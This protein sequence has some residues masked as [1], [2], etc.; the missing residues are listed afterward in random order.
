[1]T[2]KIIIVLILVLILLPTRGVLA[3]SGKNILFT[4][5]PNTPGALE[6]VTV[7]IRSFVI[8]LTAS[9]VTWYLDGEEYTKG[10]NLTK[11]D[12]ITEDWGNPTEVKA[13]A[14]LISGKTLTEAITIYPTRVDLLW[15]ANSYTPAFYKGKKL[16]TSGTKII[17]TAEPTLVSEKGL[18][19]PKSL[20]YT[21]QKNNETLSAASG[22]GKKILS[23]TAGSTDDNIKLKVSTQDNRLLAEKQ[24]VINKTKP[25]IDF[26]EVEPLSGINWLK[27]I[28][29]NDQLTGEDITIKAEPYFFAT[30]LTSDNLS[31]SWKV[32]DKVVASREDNPKLI[33]LINSS[34]TGEQ[35]I[36]LAL[37]IKN[38]YQ[39]LQTAQKSLQLKS[40]YYDLGF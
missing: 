11:I 29:N 20:L 14:K 37:N 21:W 7:S 2:R 13:Q 35:E 40:T 24:I 4:I 10:F 1:M 5:N 33:T 34:L 39:N 9:E 26:Y 38:L 22:I 36:N 3:E 18:I 27:T 25:F 16:A 32:N 31:Y 15:H 12:F 8:N 30:T 23:Y 17:I 19:D 28:K 6:E